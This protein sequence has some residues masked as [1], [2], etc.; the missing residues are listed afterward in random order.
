MLAKQGKERSEMMSIMGREGFVVAVVAAMSAMAAQGATW[1]N[2]V[3]N[4]PGT[5]YEWA[6]VRN[7]QNGHVPD[8]YEKIVM[9]SAKWQIRAIVFCL[10]SAHRY[11]PPIRR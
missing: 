2:K 4:T 6:D 3:V 9:P 7:W 8:A 11:R 1:T 10:L 5:A